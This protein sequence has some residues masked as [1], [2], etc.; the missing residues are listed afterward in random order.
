[1]EK[2]YDIPEENSLDS[3]EGAQENSFSE[4]KSILE[5]ID[6]RKDE[7]TLLE[8]I[9]GALDLKI[10][11]EK[12]A[13]ILQTY[14]E[15]RDKDRFALRTNIAHSLP[16]SLSVNMSN[17]V[18]AYEDLQKLKEEDPQIF[19]KLPDNLRRLRFPNSLYST[20]FE[21]ALSDSSHNQNQFVEFV[22]RIPAID[23]LDSDLKEK[24]LNKEV[25]DRLLN[26]IVF[27]I[28]RRRL[29]SDRNKKL[30]V[31]VSG[32]ISQATFDYE[33]SVDHT[34]LKAFEA[35]LIESLSIAIEAGNKEDD[36]D[37]RRVTVLLDEVTESIEINSHVG[38]DKLGRFSERLIFAL[39]RDKKIDLGWKVEYTKNP[40]EEFKI[41]LLKSS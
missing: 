38:L 16:F 20:A 15:E 9:E 37:A 21:Y 19:S 8:T 2:H 25:I 28:V 11:L 40:E 10:P 6:L 36:V 17:L 33:K 32:Q 34:K 3:L 14:N 27:D 18:G 39:N 31:D 41:R 22:E 12:V 24:G 7:K 4:K 29:Y 5:S 30:E 35:I 13:S 23:W 26:N 1:M